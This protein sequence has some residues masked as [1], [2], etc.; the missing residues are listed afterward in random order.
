MLALELKNKYKSLLNK[1]EINTPLRLSHFFAQLHHESGGFTILKESLNYSVEGLLKT[2]GRHRISNTQALQFGRTKTRPANQEAIAN[3]IYGGDWGEKNLG[4]INKGDGW[5]FIGR[6]F[7]QLTGRANYSN[8]SKD[9]GLDYLNNPEWLEK[10]ADAIISACW[11]WKRNNC[12]FF[13][14]KNDIVGLTKKIN[15][16][17]LGLKERKKWLNIYKNLIK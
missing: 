15:G 12:N 16:G 8:L 2:F 7:K 5:K 1:Y 13:A 6:G 10:E 11:F 9:T 4:N 3:I 17:L 14:D